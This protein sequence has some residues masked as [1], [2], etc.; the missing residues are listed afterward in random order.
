M[1]TTAS[2]WLDDNPENLDLLEEV[3]GE[4][5][6]SVRLITELPTWMKKRIVAR[7]A[8]TFEQDYWDDIS[9][10]TYGDAE[11]FL[12]KGLQEGWSIRRMATEMANSF[13]GDTQQYALRRSTLIARTE[14]G[15]ALNG[16]RRDAVD[17]LA[18][19][20]GPDIPMKVTWLSVLGPTTRATHAMLDGV[21]ADEDGLWELGGERV[22]WPGHWSLPIGERANCQCSI[23][24]E[25]G[26][27]DPEAQQ[28]IQDYNDR[29]SEYE[30]AA[31]EVWVK[32]GPG[33]GSLEEHSDI[34]KGLKQENKQ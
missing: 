24:T 19:I 11:M 29:L 7:L 1:P 6:M 33:S 12:A 21:P 9:T 23:S 20:L 8:E 17:G 15:N 10:T 3:V 26:M 5:G 31:G 32:G 34:T 13:M 27:M 2:Q 30:E 18:E 22:P 16:A 28:L 25:F 4:A 14:S